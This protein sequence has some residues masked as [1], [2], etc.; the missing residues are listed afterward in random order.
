MER[1][2]RSARGSA[3]AIML[4]TSISMKTTAADVSP[5]RTV[6]ATTSQAAVAKR[7]PSDSLNHLKIGFETSQGR[8]TSFAAGAGRVRIITLFYASC[9]MACPLTL[10]TL[11]N[12]DNALSPDERSRFDVL[13][14]TLDPERDTATALHKLAVRRHINEQRWTL[15]RAS[16]S[17]TRVLA[18]AMGIQ[19]RQLD[20]GSFNHSSTLILLDAQ[21][22]AIARSS[23]MGVPDAQFVA[24]LRST[25]DQSEQ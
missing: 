9:P 21:G 14:I 17:D 23:R 3:L 1:V 12:I 13:L 18:G 19:Y 5:D 11:R 20:D 7:W 16:S 6:A 10:D 2:Y 4:S 8:K 25:I 24:I 15:G 22:R